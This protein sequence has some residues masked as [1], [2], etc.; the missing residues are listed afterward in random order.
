[1]EEG[2]KWRRASGGVA[3]KLLPLPESLFCSLATMGEQLCSLT[4][5]SVHALLSP[6]WSSVCLQTHSKG[7]EQLQAEAWEVK[8]QSKPLFL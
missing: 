4:A 3:E 7:M 8:S 1:M 6:P 2:P 5:R